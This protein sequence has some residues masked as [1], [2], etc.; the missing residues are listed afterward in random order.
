MHSAGRVHDYLYTRYLLRQAARIQDQRAR[1]GLS[2]AG[3]SPRN[4]IKRRVAEAT[5]VAADLPD[6]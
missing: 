5:L 4:Q 2:E 1:D 3:G 6:V